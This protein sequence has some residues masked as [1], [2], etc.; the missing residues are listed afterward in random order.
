MSSVYMPA[1][2]GVAR[3]PPD[4][5]EA[6]RNNATTTTKASVVAGA[7]PS[8]SANKMA[9]RVV[10]QLEKQYSP[11]DF[12]AVSTR[13]GGGKAQVYVRIAVMQLAH[14]LLITV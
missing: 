10:I 14:P 11:I 9:D 3:A 5:Y 1:Q 6:T 12:S 8:G 4:Y 13:W 7:L 2:R